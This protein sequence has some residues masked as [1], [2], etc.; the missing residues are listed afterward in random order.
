MCILCSDGFHK[1]IDTTKSLCNDDSK[2]EELEAIANT[3][4]IALWNV[5]MC[6]NRDSSLDSDI[7]NSIANDI[8]EFISKHP[9]L[10]V[11]GFNEKEAETSFRTYLGFRIPP[12]K[13]T[14]YFTSKFKFSQYSFHHN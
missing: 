1:E 9:K 5:L 4:H 14:C 2:K 6:A 12:G 3:I 7:K 13:H 10:Q 11:Q 8:M